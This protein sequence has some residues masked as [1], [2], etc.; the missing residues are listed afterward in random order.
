MHRLVGSW[1]P[2][3]PAAAA[4]DWL[5]VSG[6]IEWLTLSA[7]GDVAALDYAAA[8]LLACLS[9]AGK[10]DGIG[11]MNTTAELCGGGKAGGGGNGQIG[12]W[13]ARPNKGRLR[14][15]RD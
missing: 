7:S 1:I 5:A 14:R 10:E 11:I 15:R 4:T 8:D 3:V 6:R 9:G 13:V 12:G 2:G